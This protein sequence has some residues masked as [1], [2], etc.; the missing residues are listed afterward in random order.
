V[1]ITIAPRR[2][3]TCGSGRKIIRDLSC[4]KA[5]FENACELLL[6]G[7]VYG[8][9]R[10]PISTEADKTQ[11]AIIR[12]ASVEW[13]LSELTISQ[14][15]VNNFSGYRI[16]LVVLYWLQWFGRQQSEGGVRPAKYMYLSATGTNVR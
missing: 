7:L 13:A 8:G 1:S 9:L 16:V 11:P 4:E 15:R 2:S 3:K 6:E 12:S 5:I 14:A 10:R